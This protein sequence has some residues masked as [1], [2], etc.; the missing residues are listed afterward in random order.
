MGSPQRPSHPRGADLP[1]L[2]EAQDHGGR[3]HHP[4]P[5]QRRA[6][7]SE[8]QLPGPLPPLPRDQDVGGQA[9]VAGVLQVRVPR[10]RRT[11]EPAAPAAFSLG[12]CVDQS[13]D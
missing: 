10:G 5:G 1:A 2:Q 7:V 9:E 6:K 3:P 4:D 8:K 12:Y 13:A 11:R